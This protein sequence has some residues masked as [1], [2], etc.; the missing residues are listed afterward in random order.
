LLNGLGDSGRKP[1]IHFKT[2]SVEI[3][4]GETVIF[5]GGDND[6]ASTITA[7]GLNE[8]IRGESLAGEGVF[9]FPILHSNSVTVTWEELKSPAAAAA[10]GF[11]FGENSGPSWNEPNGRNYVMHLALNDGANAVDL[12]TNL[13]EPLSRIERV[14]NGKF[15]ADNWPVSEAI[16]MAMGG[17][18]PKLIKT[19]D[20]YLGNDAV[21][22]YPTASRSGPWLRDYNPR[23]HFPSAENGAPL[24]NGAQNGDPWRRWNAWGV[25]WGHSGWWT[26]IDVAETP[27]LGGGSVYWGNGTAPAVTG[28]GGQAR[29]VL[30]DLPV[31][32]ILSP[33]QL[34]HVNL[35]GQDRPLRSGN[36]LNFPPQTAKPAEAGSIQPTYIIGNSYR[37]PAVGLADV[38]YDW[39]YRANQEI[40]DRWFAS[41]IPAALTAA[42]LQSGN[43]RNPRMHPIDRS[44]SQALADLK[45]VNRAASNLLVQGMFN[46][47]STSVE[48]WKAILGST[49]NS[50][51]AIA[52]SGDS[53]IRF[54]PASGADTD[55]RY[56]RTLIANHGA[57]EAAAEGGDARWSGVVKLSDDQ[58][59]DLAKGIVQRIKDRTKIMQRP[60]AS[61]SELI[62]R[63]AGE[64]MGILQETFDQK[65]LPPGTPGGTTLG[66]TRLNENFLGD[67]TDNGFE[68]EG[69][70]GALRQGDFLQAVGSFVNVRSDTFRIRAYGE[71]R[72]GST[73]QA[74]AWCEVI[75]QRVP[76]FTNPADTPDTPSAALTGAG[77]AK[78]GRRFIIQSFRW[79]TPTEL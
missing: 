48:A 40:W 49:A 5:S 20:S 79:L 64:E 47:N 13:G 12:V 34:Q 30:F 45:N 35:G 41:G 29:I 38:E 52:G 54:D 61:L 43:L 31:G 32:E 67:F 4:P 22:Y 37:D 17:G 75:V 7:T 9:R 72:S 42:D 46:M 44:G 23:F 74:Q 21:S 25:R 57:G 10:T 55:A 69:A 70:P 19:F 8:L 76:E 24:V 73:V 11:R 3:Q 2:P 39:S 1:W 50:A 27:P 71:K 33:G 78:F 60:F 28:P 14:G 26:R 58:L 68:P 62:N 65:S 56:S 36:R 51:S 77:N 18:S 16:N 6:W 15:E 66:G 59:T 53:Q 63:P